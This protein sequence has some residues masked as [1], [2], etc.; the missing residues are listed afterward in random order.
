[1]CVCFDRLIVS[2][3]LQKNAEFYIN[4][5]DGCESVKDFCSKVGYF[6][7][8]KIIVFKYTCIFVYIM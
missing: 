5:I 2:G 1:M 8:R 6:Y 7:T 4:F 3:E